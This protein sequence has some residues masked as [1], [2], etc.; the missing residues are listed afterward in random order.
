MKRMLKILAMIP[1]IIIL[2]TFSVKAQEIESVE[3]E[4]EDLR[5]ALSDEVLEDMKGLGVESYTDTISDS[6]SFSSVLE[7]IKDK[8]SENAASPLSVCAAVTAIILIGAVLEVYRD[9]LKRTAMQEVLEAVSVTA[10]TAALIAPILSLIHSAVGVIEASANLML[11]FIPVLVSLLAFS[12]KLMSSAGYYGA[13]MTASQS[14][15]QLSS[16]FISPLLSLS[17]ALSVSSALTNQI[18]L[19][20]FSSLLSK[21][22]KW[23]LAFSMSIFSAV[24]SIKSFI[25]NAYDSV[26]S[27]AVRFSLSSFIPV[28]GAAVSE[29]YKTVSGSVN[30]LRAGAG[31]YVIIAL[32]VTFLP[33]TL[34]AIL[35]LLSVNVCKAVGEAVGADTI[36]E[37]LTSVS[38]VLTIL[39]AVIV[40]VITVFLVSSAMLIYAGGFV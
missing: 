31:V 3:K 40:S 14:V 19:K 18:R 11:L 6:V 22:I 39:I 29:A 9:S 7:L 17:M 13:L 23:T 26:S 34:K 28:V 30:M 36:T 35:Y 1:L 5:S 33:L 27:R 8:L 12:G 21:L 25:T 16:R 15:S 24:L 2:L 37:L 20:G 38:D 4:L 10:I 32:L